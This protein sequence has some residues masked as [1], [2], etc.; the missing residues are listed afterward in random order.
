MLFGSCFCL[1]GNLVMPVMAQESGKEQSQGIREYALWCEETNIYEKRSSD[2]SISGVGRKYG[3]CYVLEEDGNWCYVESGSIRGFVEKDTLVVG[4]K[5]AELAEKLDRIQKE[6]KADVSGRYQYVLAVE[7][8][9]EDVSDWLKESGERKTT[10][11]F[12]VSYA[13]EFVGHSYVWG[14]TDLEE[15]V[16]CSGYVQSIYAAYEYDLPRTVKE[17]AKT[18]TRIAIDDVVP[19][20]LIFYGY[21]E[22]VYH[23]AIYI[24]N[25]KIVHAMNEETGIVISDIDSDHAAFAVRLIEDH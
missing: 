23:V 7:D 12:L 19:G 15:G 14:S 20:D 9:D 18:G 3:T 5:A 11:E 21:E 10:R 25:E 13:L 17:Q 24:G 4:E 1:T 22:D 16:D 6:Q 2:S 8:L